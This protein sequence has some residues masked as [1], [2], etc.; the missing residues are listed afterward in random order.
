MTDVPMHPYYAQRRRAIT[1]DFAHNLQLAWPHF[2]REL[3]APILDG[4][5]ERLHEEL[6]RR[7]RLL[8]YVGGSQGRM[9]PFFEQGAGFFAVGRVLRSSGV[10]METT[11]LLMRKTFLAR[12]EALTPEQR[13]AFGRDWLSNG[14]RA[15]LEVAAA[16][17]RARKNPGDFVYELVPAGTAPDGAPFEF[18]IDYTECGFCKLCKAHGDEDLLPVMCGLDEEIYAIRGIKLVRTTTLASGGACCNFRFGPL[19]ADPA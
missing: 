9:T 11:S 3:A 14:N 6:Q 12:F 16:E 4:L 1:E 19:P 13:T 18:G 8:P 15:F 10:P 17:S 2:E 5:T 7:L